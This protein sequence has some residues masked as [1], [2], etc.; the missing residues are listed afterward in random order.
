M[1]Y[2]NQSD[3][4]GVGNSRST[5]S[6]LAGSLNRMLAGIGL[7]R[8]RDGEGNLGPRK[9]KRLA[10]LFGGAVVLWLLSTTVAIV[11]AGSVGV[12]V[13]LGHAGSPLG[14]GF[15][16]TPPLTSMKAMSART[17]AYTMVAAPGEGKK[18][19]DSVEVLGSDGASGSVDSTVLYRLQAD[20]A[21]NVYNELGLDY[22]TTLIRPSAR[23]CIRSVFTNYTMV[24]AAT[25][26]WHALEGDVTA[27]MAAKMEG[28]GILLEDF[29]LREVR[30]EPTLQAADTAKTAAQQNAERQK[31]ELSV[32][33][34]QAE[35][36]RVEANATADAQQILACGGDIEQ[37]EQADGTVVEIIVPKSIDQCSQAQLTPQYLQ[38]TY[39]QALQSLVDSP[40]NSTIILPFDQALTPLLNLP[41]GPAAPAGE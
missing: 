16:I 15:H 36:T 29:Q 20:Q 13:T 24:D 2:I 32:A 21:T 6:R 26:A 37:V 1:T 41:S 10:S 4:A 33:Q 9:W 34:Q 11:P 30:L 14:Q 12:P 35:I 40:N 27:C 3:E 8:P 39:I 28:R 23:T 19:D 18:S 25:T 5:G 7:R 22:V 31:F 38:W 17:T